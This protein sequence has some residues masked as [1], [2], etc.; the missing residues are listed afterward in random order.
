MQDLVYRNNFISL[1]LADH[2]GRT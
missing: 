2:K 1:V